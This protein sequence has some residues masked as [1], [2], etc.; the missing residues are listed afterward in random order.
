MKN[1]LNENVEDRIKNIISTKITEDAFSKNLNNEKIKII[2]KLFEI[3][4]DL[5]NEKKHFLNSIEKKS[6]TIDSINN[7]NEIVLDEFIYGDELYYKD[8]FG[9]IWNKEAHIIGSTKGD[10]DENNKPICFFFDTIYNTNI[11]INDVLK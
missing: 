10:L 11:N 8:K 3:F 4:P 9:V 1:N 2:E 6:Q 5:K 7:P